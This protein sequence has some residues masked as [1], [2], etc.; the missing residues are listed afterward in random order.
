MEITERVCSILSLLGAAFVIGTFMFDKSFHRPINRL[1]FYASWGNVMANIGTL[2]SLSGIHLGIDGPLCQFQAFLVQWYVGVALGHGIVHWR[3]FGR[4]V[5]ADALWT[6]VMAFNVYLTFF[7]EYDAH[8]LRLLEPRYLLF[9]YGLPF[10]PALA[11][12]F[13]RS[14]ARGRV[15][16]SAEVSG[17]MTR[18]YLL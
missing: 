17:L 1:V 7:Q 16:G 5:I 8:Q 11:F 12:C 9:C 13:I 14:D 6:F 15:Y 4:F 2:I 3:V 10:I 18:A